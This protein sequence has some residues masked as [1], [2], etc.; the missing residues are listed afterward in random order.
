MDIVFLNLV[1]DELAQIGVVPQDKL[2]VSENNHNVSVTDNQTFFVKILGTTNIIKSF[3]TE[4]A[5]SKHI[6]ET[7]QLLHNKII[8]IGGKP[9]V[10]WKFI[11]GFTPTVD[12][13]TVD[14]MKQFSQQ[15]IRTHKVNPSLFPQLDTLN[16]VVTNIKRRMATEQAQEL[17]VSVLHDLNRLVDTFVIP[18]VEAA[19]FA[20][21]RVCHSDT[22]IGNMLITEASK[23]MIIDYESLKFAPVEM[24]LAG[25]YQNLVQG[26]NRQDLFN[27][28]LNEISE[29]ERFNKVLFKQ[30]VLMRNVSTT[31]YVI[32]HDQELAIERINVLTQSLKTREL[33]QLLKPLI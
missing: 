5:A 31:T 14:H 33:P 24:D 19:V 6:P 1:T 3:H 32:A 21:K 4:I 25:L 26:Y 13:V 12:T 10:I 29:T 22:H 8:T 28:C 15:L 2:I 30:I 23:V 17:P 7:P 18:V 11:N 27:V 20:Q 16:R 9:A